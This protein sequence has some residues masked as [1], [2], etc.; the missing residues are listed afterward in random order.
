[1][2]T[3]SMLHIVSFPLVQSLIVH[4]AA[5]VG[6]QKCPGELTHR[7]SSRPQGKGMLQT[8]I[9]TTQ[10]A[11]FPLRVKQGRPWTVAGKLCESCGPVEGMGD[12]DIIFLSLFVSN[13]HTR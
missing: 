13:L 12:C 8:D 5:F 11:S 4:M 7:Y 10:N 9:Q 6:G 2:G 1:M 3:P